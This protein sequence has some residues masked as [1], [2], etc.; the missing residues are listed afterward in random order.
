MLAPSRR[1]QDQGPACAKSLNLL[2]GPGDSSAAEHHARRKGLVDEG[3]HG[4]PLSAI[5]ARDRRLVP[6][7]PGVKGHPGLIALSASPKPARS[8]G[9]SASPLLARSGP[10][11]VTV[12]SSPET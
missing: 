5:E 4:S 12:A 7:F 8:A 9:V 3:F 10:S 2:P 1:A 6:Y 11:G